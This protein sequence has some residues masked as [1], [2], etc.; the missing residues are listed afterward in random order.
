MEG[1]TAHAVVLI[2]HSPVIEGPIVF[3]FSPAALCVG[4][5]GIAPGRWRQ[6]RR[7]GG[8]ARD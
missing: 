4:V 5:W 2:W 1:T 7:S 3:L 8:P 6:V